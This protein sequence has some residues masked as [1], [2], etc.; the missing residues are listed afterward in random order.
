MVYLKQKSR[1]TY[2]WRIGMTTFLIDARRVLVPITLS[3]KMPLCSWNKSSVHSC[4]ST[5][6]DH[7]V[8]LDW[9]VKYDVE[10]FQCT[11][12]PNLSLQKF[13]QG[14]LSHTLA[15]LVQSRS[16]VPFHVIIMICSC[17]TLCQMHGTFGNSA[18]PFTYDSATHCKQDLPLKAF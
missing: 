13:F 11:Y 7:L 3:E 18:W 5:L 2:C 12:P 6:M 9:H 17:L 16:F 4:L 10:G 1:D 8:P 14:Q 15:Y